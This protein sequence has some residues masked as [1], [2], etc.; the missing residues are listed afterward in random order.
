[1]V[2]NPLTEVV[3]G[4]FVAVRVRS[5][6]LMMHVLRN[7]KRR[8]HKEQNNKTGRQNCFEP[9]NE[10]HVTHKTVDRVPQFKE[11]CQTNTTTDRHF[12]LFFNELCIFW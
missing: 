1:M 7:G 10:T 8:Q 9:I 6:Q 12:V 3:I 5:G 4:V 11:A 2:L